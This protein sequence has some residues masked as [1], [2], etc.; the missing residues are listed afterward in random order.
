M[1]P[2]GGEPT[3]VGGNQ[4]PGLSVILTGRR[5]VRVQEAGTMNRLMVGTFAASVL[6]HCPVLL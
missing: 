5:A 4:R 2:W 1:W 3:I 6:G